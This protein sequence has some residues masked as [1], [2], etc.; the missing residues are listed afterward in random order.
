MALTGGLPGAGLAAVGRP[1]LCPSP[2]QLPDLHLSA[3]QLAPAALP[4]SWE[5][6]SWAAES[7]GMPSN[8]DRRHGPVAFLGGR[9]W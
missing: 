2:L 6:L 1:S 9:P 4:V 5:V 8:G 3:D 7:S